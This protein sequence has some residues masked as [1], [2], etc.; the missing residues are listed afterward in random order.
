[1]RCTEKNIENKNYEDTFKGRERTPNSAK[2]Y[3]LKGC[4]FV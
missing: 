4:W 1:M 3:F 2:Y